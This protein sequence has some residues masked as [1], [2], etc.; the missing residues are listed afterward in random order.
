[1][2]LCIVFACSAGLGCSIEHPSMYAEDIG[3]PGQALHNGDPDIMQLSC[4]LLRFE[5]HAP[6]Q[7]MQVRAPCSLSRY[8]DLHVP[9][10]KY[11]RV[12]VKFS[13]DP[14]S[15]RACKIAAWGGTVVVQA[16][17][18]NSSNGSLHR[19]FACSAGSPGSSVS[20]VIYR[21]CI[22]Y[23][24]PWSSTYSAQNVH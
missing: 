14:R 8:S 9:V 12:R 6:S 18:L 11:I 17:V 15:Q 22:L 5:H 23:R 4:N 16:K 10:V 2:A 19:V 20:D 7:A 24:W 3:G 21:G 1:M 13:Q